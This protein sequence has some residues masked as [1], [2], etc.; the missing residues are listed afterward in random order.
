MATYVDVEQARSLPGLRL[1]LTA[2]VPGPWSE[3]AK[4]ILHVKRLPVTLVRQELGG[5]NQALREWTGQTSAPVAAWQEERPRTTSVEILFL[6]ERLAPDPPLVPC[7]PEQRAHMFGLCH[8]IIGEQ[9]FGW[10]RRLMLLHTTLTYAG[11]AAPDG[12]RRMA[13]KYGYSP[14]AAAAAPAR[15]AEV[16]RLLAA[17]LARQRAAGSRFLIGDRLS[18]LDVYWATFAVLVAPLPEELCPMPPAIRSVY[19]SD[20]PVV[21]SAL[22]PA[23]LEHRDFVY[24]EYL[25]LPV[26]CRDDATRA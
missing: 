7:D 23:L 18:A 24:R 4:G 17:Q 19:Q 10:S 11:G 16:L 3:A 15:A 20:D 25:E 12:I 9:G 6:A 21:R 22:D 26:D 14:E 2:G 8:E 13:A 5:E 1:V